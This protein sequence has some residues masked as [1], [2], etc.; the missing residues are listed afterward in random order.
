YAF[1]G[2]WNLPEVSSYSDSLR[3]RSYAF[4][5]SLNESRAQFLLSI[6]PR[7]RSKCS[8]GYFESSAATW[9][10]TSAGRAAMRSSQNS[11]REGG[12]FSDRP[13]AMRFPP[14]SYFGGGKR[15]SARHAQ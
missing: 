12:F 7:S 11:W 15:S 5:A 3:N 9:R 14:I 10:R 2:A 6:S 1:D 8:R 4:D 13:Q